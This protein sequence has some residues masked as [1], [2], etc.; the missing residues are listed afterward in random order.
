MVDL[1]SPSKP[2][3][4]VVTLYIFALSAIGLPLKI[5][6]CYP[7]AWSGQGFQAVHDRPTDPRPKREN[8]HSYL[9]TKT[10]TIF[11]HDLIMISMIRLGRT[12]RRVA[13]TSSP[14]CA[15]CLRCAR[16]WDHHHIPHQSWIFFVFFHFWG[17][18]RR[19]LKVCQMMRSS[20]YTSSELNFFGLFLLLRIFA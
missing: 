1:L 16:R 19:M 20:S 10:G 2:E 4:L 8:F 6:P 9:F 15:E 18:L 11:H 14:W 3:N 5:L 17:F 13:M 12:S 7:G